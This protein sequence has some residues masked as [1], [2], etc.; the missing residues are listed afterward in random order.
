MLF[1]SAS[2]SVEAKQNTASV[3]LPLFVATSFVRDTTPVSSQMQ[4]VQEM[5][6]TTS[7]PSDAV[8]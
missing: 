7:A 1:A 3:Q 5:L 2:S 4:Q 6:S 8:I